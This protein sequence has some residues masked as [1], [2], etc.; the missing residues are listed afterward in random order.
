M[1][2]VDYVDLSMRCASSAEH[3]SSTD[4]V[5]LYGMYV[6]YVDLSMR[7]AN[8]AEHSGRC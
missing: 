6:D 5:L 2:V 4:V 7:C 8:I 3:C 1:Y